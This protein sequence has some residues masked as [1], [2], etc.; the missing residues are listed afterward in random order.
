M[1]PFLVYGQKIPPHKSGW[2][3]KFEQLGTLLPT[4]NKYRTAAGTPGPA[5]WQQKAGY[6]IAVTLNE[7]EQ[8]I[9]GRETVTL[10]NHS[11]QTL[12]Y[13]WLQL[14]Q[15]VRQ[16]GGPAWQTDP[17][18]L[19]K[20]LE[21]QELMGITGEYFY[22]GGITIEEV[23]DTLGR[24]LNYTINNTMM[25]VELPIPLSPGGH[26]SIEVAWHYKVYDRLVVEGR[27]GYEYFPDDDNYIFTIAQWYPRLAV[28][29]DVE[30][31]QNK[32]FLGQGEFALN[33]ADFD[34]QI[35]VPADHLVAASGELLNADEVLTPAQLARLVQ[36]RQDTLNPVIIVSEKE[37]RKKEKVKSKKSKTWHFKATNVRDFV[38][39]SSRK[40]IWDAMAVPLATT[41]PL[42]MSFYPK[43]GNPLWE[44]ES[45][46]AVANAL[47]TY[48]RH[49]FDYPY[50]VAISIHTAEQ[51]MEYP[52]ICFN[53]GR[54]GK[55]GRYS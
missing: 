46:R 7:E 11:P 37:A 1:L 8:T 16:P 44:K 27:G 10:F 20:K 2:Q 29:D 51:G 28:Y 47:R 55:T 18:S 45:T 30:G 42:A 15:N 21:A 24:A 53:G 31:W 6:R 40:F 33:F 9:S 32:Q 38:F 43:E 23:T 34:V 35:T 22:E 49:T 41:R 3:G 13:L 19:S 39:A 14:D 52:M 17:S 26:A 50:P 5:Y 25:R 12:H 48:S 36:A 4:P 54:P